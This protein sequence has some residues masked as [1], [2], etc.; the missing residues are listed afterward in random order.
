M[1]A[2]TSGSKILI[3]VMLVYFLHG[4]GTHCRVGSLDVAA[5]LRRTQH[6]TQHQTHHRRSFTGTREDL[7]EEGR[8]PLNTYLLEHTP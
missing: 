2:A 1:R 8:P 3:L 7:W 5:Y 6:P 4:G